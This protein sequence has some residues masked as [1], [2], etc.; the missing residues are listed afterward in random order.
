MTKLEYFEFNGRQGK[1]TLQ[2][3]IRDVREDCPSYGYGYGRQT[4]VRMI[5]PDTIVARPMAHPVFTSATSSV[6][7][8]VSHDHWRPEPGDLIYLWGRKG[9]I[10]HIAINH[11]CREVDVEVKL[12]QDMDC[13]RGL[14]IESSFFNMPKPV[15]TTVE[16]LEI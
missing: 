2:G 11:S 8:S 9:Y 13:F 7:H 12:G 6:P 10:N 1:M 14:H 3:W 5:V 15:V 16:F 4:T